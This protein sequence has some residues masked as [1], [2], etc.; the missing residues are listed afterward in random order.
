MLSERFVNV[1][2]GG[3]DECVAVGRWQERG[4]RR[5]Y[6]LGVAPELNFLQARLTSPKVGLGYY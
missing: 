4:R 5:S 6:V 3:G 2:I 1:V